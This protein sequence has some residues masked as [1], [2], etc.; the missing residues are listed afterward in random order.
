MSFSLG[1]IPMGA[2]NFSIFQALL[3]AGRN[4]LSR[5][6][7]SKH[8]QLGDISQTIVSVCAGLGGWGQLLPLRLSCMNH[9]EIL[10]LGTFTLSFFSHSFVLFIIFKPQRT[11]KAGL[12]DNTDS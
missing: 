8:L 10:F 7:L 6:L 1:L 11:Q 3:L 2:D 9:L 12:C 4:E 5:I